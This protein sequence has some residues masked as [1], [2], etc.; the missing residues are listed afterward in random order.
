MNESAIT[1]VVP[2]WNG[3][4]LIA[5]LLATLRGQTLAPTHILVVDNGSTDGAAEEAAR[6]GARVLPMGHNAGFAPAVNRGIREAHTPWV[7]VVNNDVTLEAQYFARLLEAARATSAWFATGKIFR[8]AQPDV[9]DGT[10]DAVCRG[11]CAWRAGSGR[12]DG[13]PFAVRRSIPITPWTAALFRAG[14]F[15]K[16][17]MLEESFESYLE[18]V[19]FGLR[20]AAGG[21]AGVYE[22]SA[23]AWHQGG[24][25]WG[26]WHPN[27]VRRMARN[28][29]WVVARHFPCRWTWPVVIAQLLWG[30]VAARHGRLW[31]WL[32]GKVEGLRGARHIRRAD[33]EASAALMPLLAASENEIRSLQRATGF[34]LYWRLYLFFSGGGAN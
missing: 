31:S 4:R 28:Q 7:A 25:T 27:T 10:W 13:P 15:D 3:R 18:D 21:F 17:G 33:P 5:P 23:V 8:A 14:L 2:V 29:V 26:T 34:D 6:G 16:A 30:L 22:P 20:C 24:G 9:L 19:E 1:V 12:R 11:G 32:R